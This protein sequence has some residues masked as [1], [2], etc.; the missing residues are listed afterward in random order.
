MNRHPTGATILLFMAMVL[1]LSAAPLPEW[2]RPLDWFQQ[3]SPLKAGL[4]SIIARSDSADFTRWQEQQSADGVIA[5]QLGG[6][7]VGSDGEV[8]EEV[9]P[10]EAPE[11]RV[12]SRWVPPPRDTYDRMREK[13]GAAALPLVNPCVE[14]EGEGCRHALDRFFERLS[15]AEAG[16]GGPLRVVH[17][18]DSLI[19]SDHITDMIRLRLQQRFGS[20]GRGFLLVDRLSRFAGRRVRTG[21][22]SLGWELD[23]ITARNPPDRFFGYSG[24][25]FT[26]IK[27]GEHS[28]FEVGANRHVEVFYF[29]Y[30]RGGVMEIYA[31]DAL[32]KTVTTAGEERRCEVVAVTLP[33]G[34]KN[35]RVVAKK[36]GL[37]VFGVALE[38]EVPGIVYESIGLPGATSKVWMFPDPE[39]FSRQLTLRSPALL[40]TMLGGNDGLML[41]K[42]R[43]T[44]EDIE[45][46]T[47]GFLDRIRKAVP[48]ADCL[49]TS[50][51]DAARVK[52]GGSME[53]K[54]E[55]EQIIAMQK[56]VA[57]EKGCAFWD[58]WSSMGGSGSLERW[59]KAGMINPDMI[60]PK[61]YGGDL[62][63]ELMVEAVM[64]AYDGWAGTDTS[65]AAATYAGLEDADFGALSR[66]LEALKEGREGKS[67]PRV[68]ITG[69]MGGARAELTKTL[70]R[71]LP[72]RLGTKLSVA[73]GAGADLAGASLVVLGAGYESARSD[74]FDAEAEAK[75][76]AA[77]EQQLA[78]ADG[79]PCLIFGPTSSVQERDGAWTE[80]PALEPVIGALRALAKECGCAFWSARD[81]MGG[82]D[83]AARWYA[84]QPR[85]LGDDRKT[86]TREGTNDLAAFF[87]ADLS[88]HLERWSATAGG[89]E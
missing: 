66:T 23:V 56:R 58:M 44:L 79:A 60:H 54:P 71:R 88:L 67:T 53:S 22:A 65:S 34:T 35:L 41:S 8:K 20:A 52:V 80:P 47:R 85:R 72:G 86:L 69:A 68:V 5:E 45:K 7:D 64:G 84:L 83:S 57:A 51:M 16:E 38:A 61:G 30:P 2:A 74:A 17:Y 63:G 87:A 42:K 76:R 49:V 14:G 37:R 36:R 18:G 29:Q 6:S 50:P 4:S 12:R 24:A 55:V 11:R 75:L 28:D 73:E 40:V 31:D 25:S 33:P 3:E 1:G 62:L 32:L 81:A 77:V 59:H 70:R 26:A 82:K 39:N 27:D 19:A 48:E 13:V 46:H 43:T 21:K 9:V 89:D 78:T 15:A 10:E